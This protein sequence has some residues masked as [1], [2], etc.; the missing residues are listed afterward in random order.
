M[1]ISTNVQ[2]E[3]DH[4]IPMHTVRTPMVHIYVCVTMVTRAMVPTVKTSTSVSIGPSAAIPGHLVRTPRV[5]LFANA[6]M[7]TKE[8]E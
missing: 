8:T 1:Q 3:S 2:E 6:R 5:A 4:V 7:G